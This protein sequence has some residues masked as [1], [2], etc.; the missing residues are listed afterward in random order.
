MI[1]ID[2]YGIS[3]KTLT[4][5][6]TNFVKKTAANKK[7]CGLIPSLDRNLVI[8]LITRRIGNQIGIIV[9]NTLLYGFHLR[10]R[11]NSFVIR[12]RIGSPESFAPHFSEF[13][14]V[15][16]IRHLQL[17]GNSKISIVGDLGFMI[18]SP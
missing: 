7:L 15:H 16:D 17:P 14:S 10:V 1:Q 18:P 8:L 4:G 11:E 5:Y 6:N 12:I 2:S 3:I 9:R 13:R